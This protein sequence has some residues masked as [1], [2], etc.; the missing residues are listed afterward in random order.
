VRGTR[1]SSCENTYSGSDSAG[2]VGAGTL[3]ETEIIYQRFTTSL[4]PSSYEST[5]GW[6]K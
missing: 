5:K 6:E 4:G 3:T 2:F 1:D